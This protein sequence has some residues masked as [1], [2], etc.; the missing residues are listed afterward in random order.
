MIDSRDVVFF[1]SFTVLA[2]FLAFRSL[3]SRRWR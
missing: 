1:L 3:E 2:L